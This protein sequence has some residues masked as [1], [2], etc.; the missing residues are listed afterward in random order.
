[1]APKSSE[2]THFNNIGKTSYILDETNHNF[3]YL[4]KEQD[5]VTGSSA[6]NDQTILIDKK[7]HDVSN[8][9]Q[10]SNQGEHTD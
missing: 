9:L 6:Q 4:I 5:E 10:S 7:T 1:M 2:T 8:H 3:N